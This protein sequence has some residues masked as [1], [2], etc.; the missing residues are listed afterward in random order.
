M[1]TVVVEGK[2]NQVKLL[3]LAR[4]MLV[5]DTAVMYQTPEEEWLGV[6]IHSIHSQEEDA[7]GYEFDLGMLLAFPG[8]NVQQTFVY[9]N[10]KPS[11]G[12]KD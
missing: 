9:L 4:R 7:R 2:E 8:G 6:F 11:K 12:D 10:M 5:C 1:K 3:F